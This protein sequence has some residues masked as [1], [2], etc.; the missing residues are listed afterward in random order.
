MRGAR[1]RPGDEHGRGPLLVRAGL[2]LTEARR[3]HA[4]HLDTVAGSRQDGTVTLADLERAAEA[5]DADLVDGLTKPELA[6]LIVRL[7][8]LVQHVGIVRDAA[9]TE[10]LALWEDEPR[11]ETPVGVVERRWQSK[12]WV[13]WDSPALELAAT[14]VILRT[15]AEDDVHDLGVARRTLEMV[16]SLF[17]ISGSSAKPTGLRNVGIDADEYATAVPGRYQV[18]V[19]K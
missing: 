1:P 15:V 12:R 11:I 10:L 4:P 3:V 13:Q 16:G 9:E 17:R 18:R 7:D 6:D 8:A 19:L 2:P 5:C 14:N